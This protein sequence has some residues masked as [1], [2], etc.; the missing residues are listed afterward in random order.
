MAKTYTPNLH[1]ALQQDKTDKLDW[2]A[3]TSNWQIIDTAFGS[4]NPGSRSTSG[5]ASLNLSG[6]VTSPSMIGQAE[7]EGE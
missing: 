6:F 3:I 5:G 1:L 2:D 7:Q 4:Y